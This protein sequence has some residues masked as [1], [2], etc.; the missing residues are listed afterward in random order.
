MKAEQLHVADEVV[1]G[2]DLNFHERKR[3]VTVL[4][5][6]GIKNYY[7]YRNPQTRL[8]RLTARRVIGI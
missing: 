4:L 5:V 1:S 6:H 8:E 7:L 2:W 3:H